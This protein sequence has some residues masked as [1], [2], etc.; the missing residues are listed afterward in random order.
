MNPQATPVLPPPAPDSLGQAADTLSLLDR[1]RAD[2]T[3]RLTGTTRSAGDLFRELRATLLDPAVWLGLAGLLVRLAVVL[4]LAY[5]AIRVADRIAQR[6]TRRVE[7]LP[8]IHP[9]RQRAYT[10]GNLIGSTARYVA[11]PVA[12]IMV[13]GELGIQVGALL[14]T[15]GIAGLAIGFGAQTLVKD[16]ISGVFLLFD[17]T[18][19]VG[20][21]VRIGADTGTVESIG[22]RLLKV[23][24]FDGELMM[25]P[26]GELRT[27][28]NKSIGF[29]RAIVEVGV[30]YEQDMETVLPVLR[31]VADAWAAEH[32]AIL[33][34]ETPQ[35]LAI[36]GFG[37]STI[38]MRIV[39][40]VTPG[41]QGAAELE[42]RARLKRAFD[43][44]GLDLPFAPRT[45]YVRG[46]RDLPPRPPAEPPP[47][48]PAP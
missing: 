48:A 7:A 3:F 32:R 36:T 5:L 44:L 33:L 35:V 4:L 41:E 38:N 15:A 8:A 17:D 9:R 37:E 46:E 30:S 25:V 16:V 39:A 21:T 12:F 34:E 19:H 42:L 45:L 6:W 10:L 14:A 23:R 22:V 2:S 28:G 43:Q 29:A 20:D 40:M 24:K 26:A 31:Q 47:P 27:F 13:L 11:W 1:L 18:I